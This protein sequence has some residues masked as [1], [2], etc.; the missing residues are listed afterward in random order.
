MGLIENAGQVDTD[1]RRFLGLAAGAVVATQLGMPGQAQA[2]AGETAPAGAMPVTSAS[3]GPVK[4]I[5]AGV[6]SVGYVEAG[7]ADGPAVILMH[8]F[9]Y[10]IHSY[11]EVAP[12]LAAEG[13]GVIVPYFR[14]Y[15]T[16]RFLSSTARNAEQALRSRHHRP[17]ERPSTTDLRTNFSKVPR[18]PRQRSPS[19]ASLIPS[20]PPV[21]ARHTAAISPESMNTRSS[22]S[23]TRY[24]RKHPTHS[25]RPSLTP[26]ICVA[27]A[28][29]RVAA[30]QSSGRG[31]VNSG[32]ERQCTG[33]RSRGCSG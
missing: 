4:Q 12:L 13:Y 1:R 19:A 18:S 16:T 9:P 10:D 15:G 17:D 6:L 11:V 14:G 27:G 26:T 8:G 22:R 21:T 29:T 33:L 24:R 7:P 31:A 2:T 3:F 28:E 23:A 20:R 32:G 25:P 30:S 5:N